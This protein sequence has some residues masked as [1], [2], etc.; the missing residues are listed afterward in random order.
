ME[1]S[2]RRSEKRWGSDGTRWCERGGKCWSEI[3]GALEI[4]V[5]TTRARFDLGLN[6]NQEKGERRK[7]HDEG[8]EEPMVCLRMRRRAQSGAERY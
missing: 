6:A 7:R 3:V 4:E 8:Y 5:R 2:K 1:M